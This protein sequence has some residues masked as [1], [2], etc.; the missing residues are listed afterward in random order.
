[1]NENNHFFSYLIPGTNDAAKKHEEVAHGDQ[2]G[3]DHQ[4]KEAQELL[5]DWLYADEH[6]DAEEDDQCRG[7]GDH[8]GD[9]SLDVLPG[10]TKS[11][12]SVRGIFE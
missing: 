8:K 6:K 1:M 10:N 12:P 2:A 5:K 11:E 3:P 4:G 9:V 7:D